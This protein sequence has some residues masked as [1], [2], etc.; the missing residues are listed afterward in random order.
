MID[1]DALQL[2]S[3][4][5]RV[6]GSLWEKQLTTPDGYPMTLNALTTACNQSSNRDPVL[7]LESTQVE[8]AALALKAKGL[9]RVVHPG[10]GERATKFR[11]VADEV[12]D[13]D[14]GER[15]LLCVLLLRGPQTAS[16]LR[17]RSERLHAFA[18]SESVESMLHALSERDPAL[19]ALVD[20]QAGQKGARW[21]QLLEV[22][23]EARAASA[24]WSPS[25]TPRASAPTADYEQLEQRVAELEARFADLLASLGYDEPPA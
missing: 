18:D 12:L 17:A 21:I 13:L 7:Q 4:Q 19:V 2:S 11:Q 20:R 8:T 9:L 16:E 3:T 24:P 15:A 25:I 5:A 6:L 1:G 22:G 23:A 10:A 14:A